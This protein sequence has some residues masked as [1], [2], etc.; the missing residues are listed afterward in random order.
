[1]K[2]VNYFIVEI[3]KAYENEVELS[4]GDSLIINSTIE[5]VEHINRV[6]TIVAAPSFTVL[7]AGDKVV[8]HHN[9]FRLRND[10]KGNIAQSNFHIEGNT[11]FVPLT[12]VFM[13]KSFGDS[14]WRAMNPYCFVKPID[15]EEELGFSLSISEGSYK[16]KQEG[17]GIM[18]YPNEDLTAQGVKMGDEVKFTANSEYEFN[19]DG[20]LYY[21]MSTRDIT[22]VL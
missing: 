16:G 7:K 15:K 2:S 11:Y 9:I 1:M 19:I 5:S 20:V 18:C 22:A 8:V 4:T 6:A 3:D 12:E 13:V 14:D 10:V 17:V 21:K